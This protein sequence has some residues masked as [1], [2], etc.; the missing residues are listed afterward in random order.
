MDNEHELNEHEFWVMRDPN[1]LAAYR[2]IIDNNLLEGMQK[3]AYRKVCIYG[4]CTGKELDVYCKNDDLHKRLKDLCELGLL[5]KDVV[6]RTCRITGKNA[7]TWQAVENPDLSKLS[8][9]PPK[10][11]SRAK[12]IEALEA[13]VEEL[14]TRVYQLEHPEC[15]PQQTTLF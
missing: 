3:E 8:E 12:L 2:D 6:G 5:I 7:A 14:E 10:R 1:S 15:P 11:S 9:T 13:R 4:P